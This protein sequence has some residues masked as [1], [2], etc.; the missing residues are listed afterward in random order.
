MKFRQHRGGL[1]D[2]LATVVEIADKKALVAYLRALFQH[3][4]K[5]LPGVDCNYPRIDADTVKVEKYVF[6]ERINW[7]TH[8][9]LVKGYGP[10]GF[11]DGP[12]EDST[13][14]EHQV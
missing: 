13:I 2:S 5:E 12:C 14:K 7:D 11:T 9:V 3:W 1:Q 10:I 6:D 4:N 8:I